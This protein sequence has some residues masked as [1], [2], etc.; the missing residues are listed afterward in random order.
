MDT[1]GDI[2]KSKVK[3]IKQKQ[4]KIEKITRKRYKPSFDF[5]MVWIIIIAFT[6][7]ISAIII[8]SLLPSLIDDITI[9]E[10]QNEPVSKESETN[11]SSSD[12]KNNLSNVFEVMP[13]V[14]SIL[15]II[16]ILA[17]AV[18]ALMLLRW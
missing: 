15:P 10:Q 7:M 6:V 2:P 11:T 5:H 1:W 8:I 18:S 4:K 17:I 14:F 9:E 16:F 3:E 13:E 12:M